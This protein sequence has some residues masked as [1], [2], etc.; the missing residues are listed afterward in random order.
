MQPICV[1]KCR[2]R[3]VCIR[4]MP[5]GGGNAISA[6]GRTGFTAPRQIAHENLRRCTDAPLTECD[7]VLLKGRKS[8]TTT[9]LGA[10]KRLDCCAMNFRKQSISAVGTRAAHQSPRPDWLVRT[11]VVHTIEESPELA[12]CARARGNAGRFLLSRCSPETSAATFPL[13]QPRGARLY[14]SRR[15]RNCTRALLTHSHTRRWR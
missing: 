9:S 11:Y 15:P 5:K 2:T 6:G 4:S 12:A 7:G 1:N 8:L 10:I 13:P 14:G 3:A